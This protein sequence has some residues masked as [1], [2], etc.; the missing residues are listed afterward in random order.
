MLL[1]GGLGVDVEVLFQNLGWYMVLFYIVFD[2]WVKLEGFFC[3]CWDGEGLLG[4]LLVWGCF[5]EYLLLFVVDKILFED[6]RVV[7]LCD[8][9]CFQDQ[10]DVGLIYVDL[11]CENVLLFGDCIG[12]LDFDD[13]GWGFCVFD[14]VI[15]LFKFMDLFNYLVF[16]VVLL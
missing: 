16:R 10:F 12:M 1:V 2:V 8:L 3:I 13:G 14:F 6:F 4:D 15:I 7:V 5:W 9:Y 11:V